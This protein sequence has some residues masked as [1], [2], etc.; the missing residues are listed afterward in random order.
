[1][2]QET[3]ILT[4]IGVV[5]ALI[6]IGAALLLGKP[7]SSSS[8]SNTSSSEKVDQALLMNKDSYKTGSDSAKVTIVEFG[9]FQCPACGAAYPNV[10]KLL[11]EE[12]N[13]I[14]FVFRNFPLPQHQNAMQGAEVALA[15]GAQG[16][17]FE[18]EDKL[19]M[20]QDTWG[21]SKDPTSY[22][23][24]YA[25]ELGLDMT[26]FED[27]VKNEK[28]KDII[29]KDKNDGIALGVN[30]TPTFFINGEKFMDSPTYDNLKKKVQE[31]SKK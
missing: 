5:T 8:P 3:K 27:A 9:D 19:F 18:M 14:R 17:F 7:D 12:K 20:N 31:L 21:E 6:I 25:G 11:D 23:T 26:T 29:D 13:N 4:G 16:K 1:M 10:K 22:F 28:Y 24:Q 15:A 2:S 30:A